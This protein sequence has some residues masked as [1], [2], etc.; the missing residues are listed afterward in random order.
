M[1]DRL[2]VLI[3]GSNRGLGLAMAQN[4]ALRAEPV[5]LLA[6]SRQGTD[7]ALRKGHPRTQIL[8]P[9]LDVTI[10][11][12]VRALARER[13]HNGGVDVLINNAGIVLEKADGS[14]Y[15]SDIVEEEFDVSE[16]DG[17]AERSTQL[18]AAPDYFGTVRMIETF[19]PLM[20]P[21]TGRVVN[22]SS[23]AAQTIDLP[24]PK[25]GTLRVLQS[26]DLAWSY[27]AA[28]RNPQDDDGWS[29]KGFRP[30]YC[31]SKALLN[32]VSEAFAVQYPGIA[33]NAACPGV[34]DTPMAA[35]APPGVVKKALAQ[36]TRLPLRLAF[37][38]IGGVSGKFWAG[39]T[40]ADTGPG[41]GELPVIV[42]DGTYSAL[43][44]MDPWIGREATWDFEEPVAA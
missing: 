18:S 11:E 24:L 9:K 20:K 23:Q 38:D 32:L 7:L 44:V 34:L 4:V 33:I 29:H 31:T 8:Y 16:S 30:G 25:T 26:N 27:L 13:E 42:E 15:G 43:P 40:T 3:T 41:F 39:K 35:D 19:L 28:V 1:T 5:V 36:G 17:M 22:I 6:S 2:T 37:E 10:D 21:G 14:N 12:S